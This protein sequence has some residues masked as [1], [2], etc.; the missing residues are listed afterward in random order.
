MTW[1]YHGPTLDTRPPF[2]IKTY[3]KLVPTFAKKGKFS[4]V[5][6]KSS[7]MDKSTKFWKRVNILHVSVCFNSGVHT[8]DLGRVFKYSFQIRRDEKYDEHGK[9][10]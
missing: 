3:T 5:G 1:T 2:P 4:K 10:C 6:G 9:K 8:L 7:K